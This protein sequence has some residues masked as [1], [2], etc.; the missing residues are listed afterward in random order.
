VKLTRDGEVLWRR[1]YG[2]GGG[3]DAFW[4][5]VEAADGRIVASGFTDRIGAGGIDGWIAVL[6]SGGALLSPPTPGASAT[7][8]TRW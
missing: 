5:G 6:A 7:A 1:E 3:R 8:R 4:G 2:E